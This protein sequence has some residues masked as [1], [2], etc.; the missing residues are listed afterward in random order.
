LGERVVGAIGDGIGEFGGRGDVD[1]H[2]A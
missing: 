1:G 2:R